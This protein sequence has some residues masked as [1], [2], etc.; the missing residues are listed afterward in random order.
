MTIRNWITVGDEEPI[1][2]SEL[3][4]EKK[5]EISEKLSRSSKTDRIRKNR[6]SGRKEGQANESMYEAKTTCIF[7]K[8]IRLVDRN[9]SSEKWNGACGGTIRVHIRNHFVRIG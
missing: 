4:E 3:S 7:A 8:D 5:K 2:F 9:R 6:V 1:V